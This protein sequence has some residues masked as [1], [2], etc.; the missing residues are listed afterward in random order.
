M[1]IIGQKKLLDEVDMYVAN[2]NIPR[3][4]ILT[5]PPTSGKTYLSKI[6]AKRISEN[7]TT[8]GLKIEE[9]REMINTAYK[10]VNPIVYII[11][12]V[13]FNLMSKQAK[14]A[15]LKVTEEPPRNAYFILVG[16]RTEIT[17]TLVSRACVLSLFPYTERDILK[18]ISD[19]DLFT[20]EEKEKIL[21]TCRFP[22]Q[23]NRF[24]SLS[25]NEFYDLVVTISEQLKG[26]SGPQ[27]F[28]L[29][30]KLKL[31]KK[32]EEGIDLD[33]LMEAVLTY[34]SKKMLEVKDIK[35]Y[36]TIMDITR[37]K[38]NYLKVTGINKLSL[39]DGW[40]LELREKLL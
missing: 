34:C 21:M 14:N 9:I 33:F 31:Y 26:L 10:V 27:C 40:I 30:K 2:N 8:I 4:I 12:G 32:D 22:G 25:I 18:Y 19:L 20:K 17:E 1:S 28:G 5:G 29:S 38:K 16:D 23:I 7:V 36:I 39:F 11:D 3:F 37:K 13:N 15:L 35:D 6:I 24:S